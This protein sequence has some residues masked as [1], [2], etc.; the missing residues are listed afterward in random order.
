MQLVGADQVLRLLLNIAVGIGWRQLRRDRRIDNIEQRVV[1]CLERRQLRHVANEI[2]HQRL[3]HT[4]VDAIHRHVVAVVGAPAKGQLRQVARAYDHRSHLVGHVHQNLCSLT[5]LSVLVGH[6]MLLHVVAD[7]LEMLRHGLGNADFTPSDAERLHQADSILMRPVGSAEARHGDADDTR[8]RKA[9]TVEGTHS[10]KQRQRGVEAAADADDGLVAVGML[11]AL[12]QGEGLDVQNLF[13][14]A[15]H[16]LVCRNEGMR[17]DVAQKLKVTGGSRLGIYDLRQAGRRHAEGG[18]VLPFRAQTVDVNLLDAHLRVDGKAPGLG[19]QASVLIDE[20]VAAKDHILR[21]LAKAAAGINIAANHAG[22][23]L[24]KERHQV[25]VL[26]YELVGGRQVEDDISTSQGQLIA[27]RQRCPH[28]L[29]YFD[30]EADTVAGA[31]ELRLTRHGDRAA[32]Q[33][34]LLLLQVGAAGKP[35]F[36]VE[37]I[38]IGQEGLGHKTEDNPMLY[39][40]GTVVELGANAHGNAH[41]GDN[42]QLAGEVEQHEQALLGL[43][44]EQVLTEKVLTAVACNRQLREDNDLGTFALGLGN[45]ALYL[46]YIIIYVG[47]AHTRYCSSHLDKTVFHSVLLLLLQQCKVSLFLPHWQENHVE[48][49]RNWNIMNILK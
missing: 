43:V 48:F 44:Q 22:T 5:G 25:V 36:L 28:I 24:G 9:E 23:L 32:R 12:A 21:R 16:I 31:E 30:A 7:I 35:A 14:S 47:H 20:C 39:H 10:D 11:Q 8:A 46:L 40:G 49:E 1:L 27:G 42:V 29:A 17:I 45:E 18:V 4:A 6:I 19:Q 37:L 41:D 33:V 3:G 15:R 38:I 26:T 2:L 13:A 34:N